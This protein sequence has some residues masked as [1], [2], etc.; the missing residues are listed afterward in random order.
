VTED[1]EEVPSDPFLPAAATNDGQSGQLLRR[2]PS[3]DARAF[4]NSDLS[5]E[6]NTFLVNV[7][8][9]G[10][11]QVLPSDDEQS[12]TSSSSSS[13]PG[14]SPDA[15]RIKIKLVIGDRI[16]YNDGIS[17]AGAL[18]HLVSEIK[19][20]DPSNEY[21][22]LTLESGD[23]ISID[24]QICLLTPGKTSGWTS[25]RNFSFEKSGSQFPEAVVKKAHAIK[26]LRAEIELEEDIFWSSL[27][28]KNKK[29]K[30]KKECGEGGSAKRGYSTA[31]VKETIDGTKS[32][33]PAKKRESG[34]AN[35]P[36]KRPWDYEISTKSRLLIRGKWEAVFA[37]PVNSFEHGLYPGAF[38]TMKPGEKLSEDAGDKFISLHKEWIGGLSGPL[39]H[40]FDSCVLFFPHFYGHLVS[41][42]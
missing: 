16:A 35:A 40:L 5:V 36:Q 31:R 27:N 32:M 1:T 33:L 12:S 38:Y 20:I 19:G 2:V 7:P 17:V 30:K 29:R 14:H 25:L 13:E 34:T 28:T 21:I 9:A 41:Q 8:P 4:E 6:L 39:D 11:S 26:Q 15:V 3:F 10:H 24:D 23:Q 18:P 42:K 22:P 37:R